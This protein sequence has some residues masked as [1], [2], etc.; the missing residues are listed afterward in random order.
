MAGRS[1][2]MPRRQ[3]LVAR[4][5]TSPAG[6][7]AGEYNRGSVLQRAEWLGVL[8]EVPAPLQFLTANSRGAVSYC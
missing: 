7:T 6:G 8:V 4:L 2:M 5:V 3:A 1:F